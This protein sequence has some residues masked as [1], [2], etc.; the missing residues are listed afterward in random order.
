MFGALLLFEDEFIH[1]VA[2]T[3]TALILTELTMVALT[4][5]TWHPLMVLAELLSILLYLLS[6]I[7]LREFFGEFILVVQL[8]ASSSILFRCGVHKVCGL[9]M[10]D[11]SHHRGVLPAP[12]L[13]QVPQEALLPSLISEAAVRY[14][15]QPASAKSNS[16]RR[17]LPLL[18]WSSS[19]CCSQLT[20]I[21]KWREM[22]FYFPW[23]RC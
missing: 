18:P 22:S 4:I 1:V 10:E 9:C 17:S 19:R 7:L 3:Y 23:T 21:K 13:H 2:I 8:S 12:L 20:D 6:L 5:R 15:F 16:A 14:V 11:S